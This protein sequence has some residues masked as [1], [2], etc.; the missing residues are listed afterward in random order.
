MSRHR[1]VAS[2]ALAA[3]L[4]A[5]SSLAVAGPAIAAD[6]T[7]HLQL[8]AD[9]REDGS[10]MLTA[11]L[12]RGA[13]VQ[14]QQTVEFFQVVD[15][16]GQRQVPLG[17][18]TT[19]AAG[20][21]SRLY[22]PTSNGPQEIVARHAGGAGTTVSEPVHITVSGAAPLIPGRGP[23]LPIVQALAFPVGAAILFLVWLALAGILVRAIHG[24]RRSAAEVESA[25]VAELGLRLGP[26]EQE[27]PRTE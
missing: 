7:P 3:S 18:A 13:A 5:I 2:M 25:A 6:P 20:T 12:A 11:T 27:A 24:I 21:A 16:F 14:S 15:F 9:E 22:T 4:F 23:V 1:P 17:S 26:V 19:D 8:V 10:W